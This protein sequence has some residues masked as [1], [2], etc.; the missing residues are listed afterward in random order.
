MLAPPP[1]YAPPL[2][3]EALSDDKRLTSVWRQTTIHEHGKFQ[4]IFHINIIASIRPIIIIIIVV[5][6]VVVHLS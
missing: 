6:V 4:K 5:G 3:Q 2:G 1:Y